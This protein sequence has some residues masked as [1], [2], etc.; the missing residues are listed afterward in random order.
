MKVE[1]TESICRRTPVP[2]CINSLPEVTLA[3][4]IRLAFGEPPSPRE[5]AFRTSLST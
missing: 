1:Q 4:L 2:D 3:H 5:K